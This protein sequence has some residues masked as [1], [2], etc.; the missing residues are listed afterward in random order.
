MWWNVDKW[1]RLNE[2]GVGDDVG[3][4]GIVGVDMSPYIYP[5]IRRVMSRHCTERNGSEGSGDEG[6]QNVVDKSPQ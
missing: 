3:I 5:H 6:L 1:W 2:G 4:V